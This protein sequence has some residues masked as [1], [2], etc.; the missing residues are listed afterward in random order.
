MDDD[1]RVGPEGGTAPCGLGAGT[2]ARLLAG[3][4]GLR[5]DVQVCA[6]RRR[7]CCGAWRPVRGAS[8]EGASR[9]EVGRGTAWPREEAARI[10]SLV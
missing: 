9:H 3:C 2:T 8:A 5:V 7:Q 4:G 6:R 1:R 10:P